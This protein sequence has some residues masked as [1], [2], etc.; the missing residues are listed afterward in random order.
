MHNTCTD[1]FRRQG[2]D[3]QVR[4]GSLPGP[5]AQ[6]A[7][8]ARIMTIQQLLEGCHDM[9]VG[10]GGLEVL[11]NKARIEAEDAQRVLL[12]ALNGLA[13]LMLL[14]NNRADAVQAYREVGH[15]VALDGLQQPCC[16]ALILSVLCQG[17]SVSL[18]WGFIVFH[19]GFVCSACQTAP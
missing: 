14:E 7:A 12:A 4:Q 1:C 3:Q 9:Q 16:E 17:G 13:A 10:S 2:Y 5:V 15:S 6:P 11:T 18:H 19:Y 8:A